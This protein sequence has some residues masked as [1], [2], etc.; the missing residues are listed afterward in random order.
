MSRFLAPGLQGLQAYTPGEQPSQPGAVI[1][2]NTNEFPA[3]PSPKVQAA[4]AETA[5]LLQWYPDTQAQCLRTA[6]AS[7]HGLA[8]EQV[9]VGNG[10]DEILAL[11]F[12][13]FGQGGVRFADYTY[14]F[15]P[16]YAALYQLPWQQLP[17]KADFSL[18]AADYFKG[19]GMVVI[20]N[21]NTPSGLALPQEDLCRII[22]ANPDDVVL[23]DEAYVDYHGQSM[24]PYLKQYEN[25]LLVRTFS[26][27]YALAGARVGYA[28][29]AKGLIADLQR[30]RSSFNPYNVNRLSQA[31]AYAALQD[32]AYYAGIRAQMLIE[33]TRLSEGLRDLGCRVLP[34]RSNFIFM[35][36]PG[37][38]GREYEQALRARGIL[39]RH[40]QGERLAPYCRI[41]IAL[42][43]QTDALLA[44]T[45]EIL[46]QRGLKA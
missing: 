42:A 3:P 15:Y 5:Q 32:E 13:A 21:P 39:V 12:L 41:S 9:V 35:Q 27:A 38:T 24:V 10:S 6:L 17:V 19:R 2:L 45:R 18:T 40:F 25:L 11:A 34:S 30:L 14:G 8:V 23:I 7:R 36:P 20:A 37:M 22:E 43:A 44:A 46:Q 31:A 16:V 28:L 33:R 26:K 4:I 1:K 29:G